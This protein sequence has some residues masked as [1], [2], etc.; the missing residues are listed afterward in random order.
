M[1]ATAPA[2]CGGTYPKSLLAGPCRR[3]RRGCVRPSRDRPPAPRLPRALV[4]VHDDRA[5]P[6]GRTRP[7]R[8][9]PSTAGR[10]CAARGAA[11]AAAATAAGP[12]GARSAGLRGAGDRSRPGP[13]VGTL[14]A[15]DIGRVRRR[16]LPPVRPRL[17]CHRRRRHGRQNSLRRFPAR[18]AGRPA[19]RQSPRRPPARKRPANALARPF[20]CS[21]PHPSRARSLGRPAKLPLAMAPPPPAPLS[22]ASSPRSSPVAAA[23]TDAAAP[24]E[25]LRPAHRALAVHARSL[26]RPANLPLANLPLAPLA[27][28]PLAAAPLS[29]APSPHPPPSRPAPRRSPRRPPARARLAN[30]FARPIARS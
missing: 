24:R 20:A 26:G 8:R 19:P 30:A 6:S 25:G 9:G 7:A 16:N 27:N 5:Q 2:S 21:H 10:P 14:G 18:S 12:P 28:L 1:P 13:T 11:I 29:P 22:F 15:G 17:A 23:S 4:G 3:R